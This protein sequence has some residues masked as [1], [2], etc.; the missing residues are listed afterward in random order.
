MAPVRGARGAGVSPTSSATAVSAG[1]VCLSA[2]ILAIWS[3]CAHGGNGRVALL[4]FRFEPHGRRHVRCRAEEALALVTERNRRNADVHAEARQHLVGGG[5]DGGLP[6]GAPA[7]ALS[8]EAQAHEDSLAGLVSAVLDSAQG[9]WA[10]IFPKL[11]ARYQPARLVLFRD[12]IKSACG[13][14]ESATGPFYCPGDQKVYIDLGFYDELEQRFGAPGDFAQ[15]YVLA[16]E[17][18]HHVQNL[19]GIERQMREAFARAG[20]E[21][22]DWGYD[23]EKQRTWYK[24]WRKANKETP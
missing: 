5:G 13:F 6:A 12:G 22:M 10:R 9:E 17:L 24:V 4:E 16:H 7:E 15:A 2:I 8:P 3:S 1:A 21:R 20:I 19:L 18:G 14:A 23:P 11:G